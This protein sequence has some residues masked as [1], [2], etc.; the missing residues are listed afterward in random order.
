MHGLVVGMRVLSRFGTSKLENN[1]SPY[2]RVQYPNFSIILPIKNHAIA[3]LGGYMVTIFTLLLLAPM[4]KRS[5]LGCLTRRLNFITS[6]PDKKLE[7]SRGINTPFMPLPLLQM[8][9]R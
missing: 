3:E 1:C 6:K 4:D 2:L 8:D 9:R 5:R 7:R